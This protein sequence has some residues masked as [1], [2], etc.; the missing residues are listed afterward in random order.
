MTRMWGTVVAAA[1][2]TASLPPRAIAQPLSAEEQA[3]SKFLAGKQSFR[4]GE[5][6]E[7][8]ALWKEAYK[9]KDNPAF[10]FNIGLAYREKGDLPKAVQFLESYLKEAPL[11]TPGR[12]DVEARV[13]ELKKMIEDQKAAAKR[14]PHGPVDPGTGTGTG[15]TGTGSTDTGTTGTGT[16]GTGTTGGTSTSTDTGGTT[17]TG[18]G[19][20]TG[21][22]S[23]SGVGGLGEEP[24]DE[25]G[26][27]GGGMRI[28]GLATGGIGLA[29]IGT[30]VVFGMKAKS[31][32]SD[33][34]DAVANGDVWT[35]ELD[36]KDKDG[37][38]AA[39]LST[40]TLGVGAAAVVGGGVLFYLGLR[41]GKTES[42]SVSVVPA[43]G[44]SH[45][46][47][48]VLGRF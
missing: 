18:T 4:L 30:G 19:A 28:A 39:K 25:G 46:G 41:K 21:T 11:N 2:L 23:T 12:A 27:G 34:E 29:L 31:A 26:G 7:A 37:R 22:G 44:P 15:T 6:D 10:L 9:L 1:L 42:S 35:E 8:I 17:G 36:Q 3:K 38:S 20:T 47:L 40:I 16:T 43:L 45:G 48:T 24:R 13:A 5:Y 14:P 33:V 32:Q